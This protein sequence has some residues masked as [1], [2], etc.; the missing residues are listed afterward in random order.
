MQRPAS[1][2]EHLAELDLIE[3]CAPELKIEGGLEVVVIRGGELGIGARSWPEL[4]VRGAIV[5]DDTDSF[6][7]WKFEDRRSDERNVHAALFLAD[8]AL[9]RPS[10]LRHKESLIGVDRFV[11]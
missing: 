9:M 10:S 1:N 8:D 11:V 5:D 7:G 6:L 4:R 2:A 3:P